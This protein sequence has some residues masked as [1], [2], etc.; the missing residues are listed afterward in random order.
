MN[1][2]VKSMINAVVSWLVVALVLSLVRDMSF[3]QALTTPYTIALSISAL[4][5]SYIGFERKAQIA[6]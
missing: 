3:M 4:V 1:T 2:F 5:C 6:E